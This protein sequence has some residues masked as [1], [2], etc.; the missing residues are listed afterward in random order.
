MS[1]D[2]WLRDEQVELA[3]TRIL[4]AAAEVFVR[5]GVGATSM[6][7]V[8]TAAGCSR[9]TLYRYFEDRDALRRA[10]VHR[11]TRRIGAQ[12]GAAVAA[13]RNPDRRVVDAVLLAVRAVRDR[14]TLH[15]WFASA[16]ADITRDLVGSSEVIAGLSA[17]FLGD[18]GDPEVALRGEW[19]VRVILSLLATPGADEAHERA[20]VERFVAP[21]VRVPA[22]G[23]SSA[24]RRPSR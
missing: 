3:A 9:A 15:A 11:E 16:N 6:G 21:A 2:R 5:K 12:I 14:P 8:A 13:E 10:F 7:D 23:A 22:A 1:A 4:D 19:L 24:S 18:P 20:L 17:G